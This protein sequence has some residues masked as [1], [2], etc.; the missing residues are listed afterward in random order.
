M[1]FGRGLP[2]GRLEEKKEILNRGYSFEHFQGWQYAFVSELPRLPTNPENP[3]LQNG[4]NPLGK[5]QSKIGKNRF[6]I[7]KTC[8]WMGVDGNGWGP[9]GRMGAMRAEGAAMALLHT[10]QI[11][12][13]GAM[14]GMGMDGKGKA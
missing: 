3:F 4:N 5:S 12:E 9:C 7:E 2:F 13:M 14:G 1:P 11:L 6:A 10:E 8:G